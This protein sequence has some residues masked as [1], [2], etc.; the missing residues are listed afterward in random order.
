MID[1]LVHAPDV[2]RQNPL[3][4]DRLFTPGLNEEQRDIEI[5][6]HLFDVEEKPEN[7][8]GQCDHAFFELPAVRMVEMAA[9]LL[10]GSRPGDQD[11]FQQRLDAVRRAGVGDEFPRQLIVEGEQHGVDVLPCPEDVGQLGS[12][13]EEF[14]RGPHVLDVLR[15]AF[16]QVDERREHVL[17]EPQR[18][19]DGHVRPVPPGLFL[20]QVDVDE[21]PDV[22][23]V[24]HQVCDGRF[25]LLEL[26]RRRFQLL[27]DFP[28]EFG[29][30]PDP[31]RVYL[32]AVDEPHDGPSMGQCGTMQ[33]RR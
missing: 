27:P 23:G 5:G 3:H 1:L 24:F 11:F 26:P 29:E 7:G 9:A 4:P 33:C 8:T 14:L 16:R 31:G 13:F 21:S 25:E 10:R 2:V 15:V 30:A 20:E 22:P 12:R 18:P 17:R 6:F 32:D 19:E 28:L